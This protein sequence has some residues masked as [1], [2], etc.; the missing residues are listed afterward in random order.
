[1]IG[2]VVAWLARWMRQ[3]DKLLHFAAWFALGYV[4]AAADVGLLESVSLGALL[5]WVKERWDKAHP[6]R[7][8]P[9][10]WDA[11]ASTIGAL[12]GV[13]LWAAV[14]APRIIG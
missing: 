8:T 13:W 4:L 10:G 7:H 6:A 12:A 9:D 3:P 11:Y 1:M 14:V 2:R 5:A